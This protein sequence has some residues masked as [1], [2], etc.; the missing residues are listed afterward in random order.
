MPRLF[1]DAI[2]SGRPPVPARQR[3]LTDAQKEDWLGRHCERDEPHERSVQDEMGQ[4]AIQ[5]AGGV[6]RAG[7]CLYSARSG[8]RRW[9]SKRNLA[10]VSS[11]AGAPGEQGAG[12]LSAVEGR[13]TAQSAVECRNGIVGAYFCDARENCICFGFSCASSFF[14][15][16]VWI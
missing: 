15:L 3:I 8:L 5:V 4:D 13:G 10:E 2:S 14:N 11:K 6:Y 12:S 16:F 9:P 7:R 1:I